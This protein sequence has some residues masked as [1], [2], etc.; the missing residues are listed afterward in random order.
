VRAYQP[1]FPWQLSS[2]P[3]RVGVQARHPHWFNPDGACI[4]G[5]N[6][7]SRDPS[8]T[9]HVPLRCAIP[10]LPT[11]RIDLLKL[12]K[13]RNVGGLRIKSDTKQPRKDRMWAYIFEGKAWDLREN[14]SALSQD[15]CLEMFSGH[16][17]NLGNITPDVMSGEMNKQSEKI[18]KRVPRGMWVGRLGSSPCAWWM[19]SFLFFYT[20]YFMLQIQDKF[21]NEIPI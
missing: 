1:D 6:L 9:R 8:T 3:M 21:T 18:N 15:N 7:G 14:R 10:S 2:V 11:S 12:R 20:S 17:M 13:E 5:W 4:D 19:C 16:G